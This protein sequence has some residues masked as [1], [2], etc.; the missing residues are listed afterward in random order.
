MTVGHA[1]AC[2]LMNKLKHIPHVWNMRLFV[3]FPFLPDFHSCSFH[4]YS[5]IPSDL[6]S[7]EARGRPYPAE[8][9]RRLQRRLPNLK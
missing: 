8:A 7:S 2:L 6:R 1:L 3:K 5:E 9:R 4:I